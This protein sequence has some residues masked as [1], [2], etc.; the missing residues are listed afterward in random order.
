MIVNCTCN[1]GS[2]GQDG[3]PC[4]LCALG[5]Y[6]A[7]VGST[8][9]TGCAH[10]K[11]IQAFGAT[12]DICLAKCGDGLVAIGEELCDDNNT[13][14]G[15]GCNSTCGVEC[16]Y[17]CSAGDR[18]ACS[19]L[20]CGDG[21]RAGSE[22]CDDNNTASGDGCSAICTVEAGWKCFAGSNCV[23]STCVWLIG[24]ETCGDGKTLG[25]EKNWSNFCDDGNLAISD[26]CSANCTVEC[27]YDCYGGNATAVDTC[28]TTCG[29]GKVAGD[30]TCDDD[31]TDDGDGCSAFCIIEHGWVCPH[32][33][34][35]K[36][37]CSQVCGNGIVTKGEQCDD[38]NTGNGDGCSATC[39][40]ECGFNCTSGHPSLCTTKCGDGKV[41]GNETCDDGNTVGGDGG[42]AKCSNVEDGWGCSHLACGGSDGSDGKSA[43]TCN[44]GYS[45]PHEGQCLSL[46]HI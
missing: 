24:N 1:A 14:S 30:E 12:A 10:G 8:Q 33:E 43:C 26:G 7:V 16:G 22:L 17:S 37:V 15:D 21:K 20:S 46:I 31:D 35:G 29:D 40:I 4:T 39:A 45:G 38:G 27:G 5:T 18:S 34:C 13:A 3:G 36:S 28:H 25:S 2:T 6:K 32:V 11:R 9:C 44:A 42:S 23:T 41:A 19:A